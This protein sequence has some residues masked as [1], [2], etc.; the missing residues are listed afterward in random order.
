MNFIIK[1]FQENHFQE[2]NFLENIFRSLA[3]AK[4]LR[5]AKNQSPAIAAKI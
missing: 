3:H 4:K 5:K 2:N 1:Y